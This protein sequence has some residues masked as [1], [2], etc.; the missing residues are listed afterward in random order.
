M[1][2]TEKFSFWLL[3]GR[4]N[5]VEAFINNQEIRRGRPRL[6]EI[7]V[8]KPPKE[9]KVP[10]VYE[11]KLTPEYR[12]AKLAKFIEDHQPMVEL[13]KSGLT[14]HEVGEKYGVTREYIRQVMRKCGV[15]QLEGGRE[16]RSFLNVDDKI[17]KIKDK[18]DVREAKCQRLWGCT[19]EQRKLFG[20]QTDKSSIVN[21]FKTQRN[22]A[23]TRGIEWNLTLL[24]WWN[25]WQE[26]GHWEER[27][28]GS[29]KYVMARECDLGAYSKE[30]VKIITHNE[31]S[32]ESRQMDYVRG[33]W[34]GESIKSL[35]EAN[36]IKESTLAARLRKG[37]SLEKALN[38]PI[39]FSRW[40]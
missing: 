36:N 16:M 24:E 27:G 6:G 7:R 17:K 21:K 26:S 31:N 33:R 3:P 10:R 39:K 37:W 23:K 19:V 25:I 15:D 32:S 35:A 11:K 4:I 13:Y 2:N 8:S 14:L 9:K 12:A 18:Q 20:K 40:S 34:S 22:S 1:L 30:N 38:E 29:G 28:I 5:D